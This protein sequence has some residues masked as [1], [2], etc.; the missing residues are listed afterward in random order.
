M[1]SDDKNL[2]DETDVLIIAGICLGMTQETAGEFAVSVQHPQ[3]VSQRTVR[4]RRDDKP[5]IYDRLISRISVAFAR[6]REEFEDLTK[7]QFREKLDRLRH[8]SVRV[9]EIVLDQAIQNP[10]AAEFLALGLKAAD[11]VEDRDF[12]KAKQ[13][14][15]HSGD[16]NH[17]VFVWTSETREQLLAQERDMLASDG[18]LK[19][20]PGEVLEAELVPET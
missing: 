15:D 7:A 3:G 17:N 9:K 13:V 8:K 14:V 12:G 6:Q 19:M 4:N 18:L 16:V 11:G 20:L 5:D 10:T 2:L 1:A